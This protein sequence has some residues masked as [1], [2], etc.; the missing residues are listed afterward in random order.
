MA[1]PFL[2]VGWCSG[3]RE[4]ETSAGHW[5]S[6]CCLV[7]WIRLSLPPRHALAPPPYP[8][9]HCPPHLL[10]DRYFVCSDNFLKIYFKMYNQCTYMHISHSTGV[11]RGLSCLRSS[12]RM[13]GLRE[14]GRRGWIFVGA[15]DW[16][17]PKPYVAK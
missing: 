15:S 9:P 6:T 4:R 10:F 3:L 17:E 1:A 5:H 11:D 12:W 7:T 14:Y 16:V 2:P 13:H 8:T